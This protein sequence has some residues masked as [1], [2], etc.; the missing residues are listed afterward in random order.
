M[1]GLFQPHIWNDFV[2]FETHALDM[3][4][5]RDPIMSLDMNSLHVN[6]LNV[7][8]NCTYIYSANEQEVRSVTEPIS[9]QISF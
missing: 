3:N 4:L 9:T 2:T 8:S 6:L 7:R 1:G 5:G